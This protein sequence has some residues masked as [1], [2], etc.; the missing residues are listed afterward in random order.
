[1]R[2]LCV[3]LLVVIPAL[4]VGA[5]THRAASLA[6][7]SPMFRVATFN[8]HKG[9]DTPGHYDLEQT[10]ETIRRLNAD[11]VG[12][13]EVMQNDA[14]LNCDDQPA[15]I[16][17]GLRRRTGR[18]WTHVYLKAWVG[19]DTRCLQR[20]RGDNANTEGVAVFTPEPVVASTFVRL[21]EGRVGLAVRLASMP[22]MP[23]VVTHLVANRQNQAGREHEVATLLPWAAQQGPGILIGDFNATPEAG[24]LGPVR[25]RY[26][27]AWAEAAAQGQID[28]VVSGSTRP[29]RRVSRI[30]YVFYAPEV[31]LA[32]QSVTVVD[33][34]TLPGLDEVSD[35]YPVVATF[36]RNRSPHSGGQSGTR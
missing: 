28:G 9:A 8:I 3:T 17:A 18:P 5:S 10:I 36:H 2:R 21:S 24:E 32:L 14:G 12:A 30:D 23:I 15:L 6:P 22:Q 4:L 29:S 20:G 1:M 35:H 26:L 34:S 33:P 13:Q 27:D 19:E 31:N 7:V 11:L 16:A 25:A